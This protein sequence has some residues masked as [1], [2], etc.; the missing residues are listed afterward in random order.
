MEKIIVVLWIINQGEKGFGNAENKLK[1]ERIDIDAGYSGKF[2][3]T[4]IDYIPWIPFFPGTSGGHE[5]GFPYYFL[6]SPKIDLLLSH[7]DKSFWEIGIEYAYFNFKKRWFLPRL[8]GDP[9]NYLYK[10]LSFNLHAVPIYINLG[11]KF[12]RYMFFKFGAISFIVWGK[13]I[14]EVYADH[15]IW[16][17]KIKGGGRSFW[18]QIEFGREY[19]F[20]FLNKKWKLSIS[21][22]MR[23]CGPNG[24][25]YDSP[26]YIGEAY[27]DL[28]GIYFNIE[29]KNILL[30]KVYKEETE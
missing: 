15:A 11:W 20:V 6:N 24:I 25:E 7:P 1:F 28:S 14:R 17:E 3:Y 2:I 19:I 18:T 9:G 30:S 12:K 4:R 22:G 23:G 27:I 16:T 5:P 13:E 21:F 8:I 29:V 26:R 10:Y